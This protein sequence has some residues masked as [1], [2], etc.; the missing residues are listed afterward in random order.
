M[1][2]C[3]Y[4]CMYVCMYVC[5]YIFYIHTNIYLYIRK[6]QFGIETIF[7][8]FSHQFCKNNCVGRF[9]SRQNFEKKARQEFGRFP[10]PVSMILNI[11]VSKQ[12]GWVSA[13]ALP[14][15]AATA[16]TPQKFSALFRRTKWSSREMTKYVTQFFN[17]QVVKRFEVAIL[18][19]H[20]FFAFSTIFLPSK[21]IIEQECGGSCGCCLD[22]GEPEC[23]S[24]MLETFGSDMST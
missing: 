20:V 18:F 23:I 2:V 12:W 3:M 19:H 17:W 4:I 22:C 21:D 7:W 9:S 1:Y 24:C 14:A 5:M 8:H 10:R 6:F 13:L 15:F 16:M 11:D